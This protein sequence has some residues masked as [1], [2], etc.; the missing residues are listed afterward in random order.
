MKLYLLCLMFSPTVS[1][2]VQR[3]YSP[4][5]GI[6]HYMLGIPSFSIISVCSFELA[7]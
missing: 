7:L 3:I 4:L 1:W 6:F 5:V 2:D